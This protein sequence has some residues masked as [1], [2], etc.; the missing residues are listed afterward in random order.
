MTYSCKVCFPPRGCYLVSIHAPAGGAT[1]EISFN[2]V[3]LGLSALASFNPRTRRGCDAICVLGFLFL[4]VFLF[5]F[6]ST[7]PQG[8]RLRK[9]FND[10]RCPNLVLFQSTHPQGVRL[11]PAHTLFCMPLNASFNPRTRR[12]C[13]TPASYVLYIQSTHPIT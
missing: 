1:S 6:Q 7:H 5:M 3:L 9:P 2:R 8:V 13:D 11:D 10:A 4:P 12:G